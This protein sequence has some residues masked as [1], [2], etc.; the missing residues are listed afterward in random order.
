MYNVIHKTQIQIQIVDPVPPPPPKPISY[1]NNIVYR[2]EWNVFSWLFSDV[3]GSNT[4]PS[5]YQIDFR[6]VCLTLLS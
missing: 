4:K 2:N 5:D 3:P 6:S 1:R